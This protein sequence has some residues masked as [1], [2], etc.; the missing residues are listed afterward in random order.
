MEAIEVMNNL[1]SKAV[2]SIKWTTLQTAVVGLSGPLLMIFKALFL[3]PAEF[4]VL[5]IVTIVIGLMNTIENFGI[6]QAVIQKDE[7]S[8]KEQ[9]SLFFFNIFIVLLLGGLLFSLSGKLANVFSM[10]DLTYLLKIASFIVIINGPSL[11]FRA[12]LEKALLFKDISLINIARN[13][14]LFVATV[15]FLYLGY[16]MVG[17]VSAQLL[18][19]VISVFLIT[20]VSFKNKMINISFYFSMAE[21]KGFLSFGIYVF[22]KQLMTFITHKIDELIIGLF[23]S[24]E[25]LGI[26]HFA[27]NMLENL[28]G[29][30][31]SSFSKVLFPLLSKLKNDIRR[32][33]NVY[34]RIS[35]Y[36][37]LFAFPI[38]IG[39]AVTAEYFVPFIFGEQWID[40]IPLFQ[41]FS[42][43]LIPLILTA[44][45]SSSLLYSI[46]KPEGVFYIDLISN[47][48]YL[49]FLLIF[50]RYGIDAVVFMYA[51]YVFSKTT[52]LQM[53][54][55]KQLKHSF[56]QYL[57]EF[58]YLLLSSVLMGVSVVLTQRLVDSHLDS[59]IIFGLSVLVG[60][61]VYM[62]S[63][64][65][66]EKNTVVRFLREIKGSN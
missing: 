57:A 23:F 34:I 13:I 32:L 14:V 12:L 59:R 40:S 58:K 61:I 43:I 42:L 33:S 19:V 15:L 4:G 44:N 26:Y 47:S 53:M 8:K 52:A 36:I 64:Y 50:S 56:V 37:G 28:R 27:K 48:A 1:K 62:V 38:F 35:K 3:S 24:S 63:V 9:S 41:A 46:G 55:S 45:L 31:T 2:N 25:I 16:G 29:L 6:S 65:K 49:I 39:I 5:A 20:F 22:G 66:L 7:I 18:S 11:L 54:T 30:I 10:P 51:M 17:V 60:A 21:I